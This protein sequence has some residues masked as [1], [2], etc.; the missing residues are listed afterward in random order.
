MSSEILVAIGLVAL[1][2]GFLIL[3][4]EIGWSVGITAVIGLI[5]YVDQPIGQLAE[6][7][8]GSL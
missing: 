1:L 3:G 5:W 7:S 2:F 8:F 6:T 4:L